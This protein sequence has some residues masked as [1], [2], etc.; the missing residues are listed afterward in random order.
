MLSNISPTESISDIALDD[1][2]IGLPSMCFDHA[3]LPSI[4][5]VALTVGIELVVSMSKD[6][7]LTNPSGKYASTRSSGLETVTCSLSCAVVCTSES[8]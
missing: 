6:V 3:G 5:I 2:L 1:S 8:G 7:H 4:Q